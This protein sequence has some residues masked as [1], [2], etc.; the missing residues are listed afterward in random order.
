MKKLSITAV[1]IAASLALSSLSAFAAED[2]N[3][4]KQDSVN[5][6]GSV[7]VEYNVNS[8]YTV[9][10]PNGVSLKD[11][12]VETVIEANNVKLEK[13]KKIKV[14][15]DSAANTVTDK[16]F[17]VKAGTTGDAP[18]ANYTIS[19]S[20][21]AL[22]VGGTVAEFLYNGTATS[23]SETLTYS[24]PTGVKYAGTYTDSL[25]FTISVE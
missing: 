24:A 5:Q 19:N 25:T 3:I 10:I 23:Y 16:Q 20:R 12:A 6:T 21:G 11:S 2:P 17:T 8:T 18:T 13:G 7:N 14:T 1:A 4:I 9:T 22:G 15:L